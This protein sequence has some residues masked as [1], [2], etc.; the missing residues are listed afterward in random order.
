[1]T[2]KR[3]WILTVGILLVA[4]D[5]L[6]KLWITQQLAVGQTSP[7]LSFITLTHTYNTGFMLSLFAA[8]GPWQQF[9]YAGI[10]AVIVAF[11]GYMLTQARQPLQRL[12]LILLM[13]GGFSNMLD[14]LL[15]PG[16]LDYIWLH[17]GAYSW[18]GIFNLA[19]VYIV[20]GL[21]MWAASWRDSQ[22]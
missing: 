8:P 21:M 5:Q 4:V 7:L 17:W 14:R 20:F 6:I 2:M 10:S 15:Y 13:A 16:V 9:F 19:D 3:L 12:G 11:L 1:M 22:C 18:P